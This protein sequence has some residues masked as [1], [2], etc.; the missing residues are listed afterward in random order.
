MPHLKLRVFQLDKLSLLQRLEKK[1]H[2]DFWKDRNTERWVLR[3]VV[4]PR[5][6]GS[7]HV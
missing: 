1:K 4:F 6:E 5:T 3:R 2:A 7:T